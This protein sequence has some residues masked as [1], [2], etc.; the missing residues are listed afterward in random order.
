LVNKLTSKSSVNELR[1]QFAEYM[2]QIEKQRSE[3]GYV[4][5][6]WPREFVSTGKEDIEKQERIVAEVL[7]KTTER[8]YFDNCFSPR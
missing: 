4:S 8:T 3:K 1:Q 6:H 7:Q 5:D 2:F